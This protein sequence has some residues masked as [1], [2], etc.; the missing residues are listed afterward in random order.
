MGGGCGARAVGCGLMASLLQK[1]MGKIREATE[2]DRAGN[3]EP[4]IKLYME[5]LEILSV[6]RKRGYPVSRP[7]CQLERSC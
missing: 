6:A 2:A 1:G 4:A 3:V 5:G 7:V